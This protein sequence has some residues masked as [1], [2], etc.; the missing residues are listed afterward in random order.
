MGPAEMF[1]GAQLP[2][3]TAFGLCYLLFFQH[4]LEERH[5]KLLRLVKVRLSLAVLIPHTRAV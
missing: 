2:V 1:A 4:R 5:S 3:S